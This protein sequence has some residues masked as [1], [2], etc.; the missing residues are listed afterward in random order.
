L[1]RYP[2]PVNGQQDGGSMGSGGHGGRGRRQANS[3]WCW[4]CVLHSYTA[5][6]GQ[7]IVCQCLWTLIQCQ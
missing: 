2:Q 5:A 1:N 6:M 7:V 4:V 3:R